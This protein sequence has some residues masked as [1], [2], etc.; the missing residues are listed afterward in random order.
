[1]ESL[2][3]SAS[4][5]VSLHHQYITED[6]ISDLVNGSYSDE[7]EI[8]DNSE[9]TEEPQR[10]PEQPADITDEEDG[11]S[12]PSPNQKGTKNGNV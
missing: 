12:A 3:A 1:M 5:E 4:S 10:I 6:D 8:T 7:F 9:H 11:N 2:R